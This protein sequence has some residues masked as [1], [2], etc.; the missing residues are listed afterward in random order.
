MLNKKYGLF[1]AISMVVGIVIGSGIFFKAQDI[2]KSTNGNVL[3]G[4]LAWVIGG[5]LMV[6]FSATFAG[7]ANKYEKINGVVDYSE[8]IVGKKYGFI[9]GW[10]LSTI[11]YPAMTSV[12]AWVSARYTLNLFGSSDITGGL[13]IALALLYLIGA[14]ALNMLT[15]KI[16]GKAQVSATIIK[17]IPLILMAIVGTIAGLVNG[18]TL[19]NLKFSA[20]ASESFDGI[21]GAI[22]AAVFAYEGWII[23]TSINSEIKDSKK[24]LP[25]ALMIGSIIVMVIYVTFF[26]GISS[27]IGVDIIINEGAPK[28]F[29]KLFGSF[30]GTLLNVFVV[31]SCLGTLNGL[32]L[33]NVRSMY[34]I[35]N[36]GEKTDIK[37]FKQVDE[38]TNV[39]NNSG[40]ITLLF[41]AVWFFY[42]YGANLNSNSIFGVFSFDSSELPILS[43]YMLYIPI[44]IIYL[45]KNWKTINIKD[46]LLNITSIILAL[47]MIFCAIYAHGIKPFKDASINGNFS[48]PILFYMI[49]FLIIMGIGIG[50]MQFKYK[51]DLIDNEC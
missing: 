38:I 21:F 7:Y 36:R 6:V 32:M 15:P 47:F 43:I 5:I 10:F 33:G 30:G 37:I 9:I 19:E 50:Y 24:N 40:V 12:L 42:F 44:F 22:C 18:T 35:S 17:L 1:T 13:C 23:A 3:L 48:F 16:A 26:I 34:S 14:Y 4:V 25:K 31:I 20:S 45:K 49:I 27:S 39:P 11:Y 8:A 41:C 51:K 29:T 28:A 46:K 2:L